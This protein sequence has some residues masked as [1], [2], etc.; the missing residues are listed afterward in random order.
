[1]D[2]RSPPKSVT[3][4]WINSIGLMISVSLI[5]FVNLF[6]TP[7]SPTTLTILVLA[8]YALPIIILEWIHLKTYQNTST[9]LNFC[10]PAHPINLKRIAFK[11]L[12]L[13]CTYLLIAVIYWLFPEYN[14]GFYWHFYSLLKTVAPYIIVLAIPYFFIIDRY[15][16]DPQDSYWQLGQVLILNFKVVNF[17]DIGQLLLGW[18]VKLFFLPLMFT[19][20]FELVLFF[21]AVEISDMFSKF[22]LF[23][24]MSFKLLVYLD[25]LI[26]TVGYILTLRIFDSH[27]RTTE[28]T[29][30]GW[31][32]TLSCYQPFWSLY[33]DSYLAYGSGVSW[34]FWFIEHPI[35]YPI[36]GSIILFL[37]A[38]YAWSSLPFGIRFSN[39][40]HRGI[41]TN[42]PYRYCKH[43]AYVSKNLSWWLIS[44]PFLSTA[45]PIDAVKHSVLLLMVNFI[46]F[47]R[48]RTEERHLS[49]DQDY[50][51]YARYIENSGLLAFV[52]KKIPVLKFKQGRLFN[53]AH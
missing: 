22:Q 44:L 30:L 24:D 12:G 39:L 38:I 4:M 46:Y 8:S 18:V 21:Q 16:V 6:K 5:L 7:F 10:K 17:K 49:W 14:Q 27:I 31:F 13:Y 28:P 45:G 50:V 32:V 51:E 11:L 48:A 41:L 20:L 15:M 40:T 43:P 26:G 25:L 37:T 35:L 42:G 2:R 1:M 34:E 53:T 47:M 9:G 52:G 36:W 23:F 3:C 33:G 19:Y 29:F